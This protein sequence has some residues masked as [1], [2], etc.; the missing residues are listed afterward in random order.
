[1]ITEILLVEDGPP[2]S[3][4]R[5]RVKIDPTLFWLC[6]CVLVAAPNDSC[7]VFWFDC[8]L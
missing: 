5:E 6:R 7:F 4:F 1:M 3:L 2:S 8:W